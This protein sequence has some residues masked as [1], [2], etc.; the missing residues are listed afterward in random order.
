MSSIIRKLYHHRRTTHLP[1]VSIGTPESWDPTIGISGKDHY[2]GLCT[3]SP[4]GQFIVAQTNKAVEIRNQLTMER[5]TVLQPTET[6]PHFTGPLVYSLDG[7][8]IA[9]ASDTAIII[10]DIQTGGVAEEIECTPNNISLAWSLDGQTICTI[11]SKDHVTFIV[12]TYDVSS[13]T[14]SSPGTLQSGDDPH[15]WTDN[16]S[17]LV[18]KTVRG[19]NYETTFDIFQVGSTLTKIQ[20]FNLLLFAEARIGPFSPTTHRISISNDDRL[21]IFDIRNPKPLLDCEW[22]RRVL[23]HCFSLDGNLFAA[24]KGN[25]VHVWK[26]YPGHYNLWRSYQ[27]QYSNTPQFSPTSSSIL[28][29]SGDILLVWRLHQLPTIL[30][31]PP[32]QYVGLSRSGTRVATAHKLGNTVTIIDSLAQT[33]PQFIDT[34][35]VIGGLAL[36]GNVLLVAGSGELVAWLL[37]KEGL[38]DVV[39]GDSIWTIPHPQRF[40]E[41]WMF[42]VEGHIGAIKLGRNALHVY[43][44]ETGEVFHPTQAP[45][46]FSSGWHYLGDALR[47]RDYLRYHNLSQCNIPPEDNWQTSRATLREGWVK[48]P[49]GKHRLWVPAE[50]RTEWDPE[51]WL[52]DTVTQ[53]S[54]LGGKH[55]IVKF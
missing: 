40:Y 22:M 45:R 7:R 23:P 30:K 25:V 36:T 37:T 54:Y 42:L 41:P 17:F 13:G 2:N 46:H 1:K 33:R 48:D 39:S 9:C 38:V 53:F 52:H 55:V 3:W 8:S 5:I 12:Y 6:I 4:C 44:T 34:N 49:E 43:H 28:G 15:L 20:S 27:C 32:P 50:W 19:E 26:Y 21:Q 16:E 10:W 51:D 18:M 31:D 35:M 47:G 14:A 29:L 24:S 11:N